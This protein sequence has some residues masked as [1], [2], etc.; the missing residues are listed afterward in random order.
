MGTDTSVLHGTLDLLILK[1]LSLEAM[2]GWGISELVQQRSADAIRVPQGSLYAS[3]H[4]LTRLGFIRSYWQETANGR[5]ARYYAL[6]TP[7][8]KQLAKE[9]EHW[10]RLSTGVARILASH[11]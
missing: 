11:A 3:L 8:R 9:T 7:G 1:L 5:R 4:R 10:T 6:T 2:H